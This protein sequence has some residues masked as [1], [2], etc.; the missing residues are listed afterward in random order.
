MQYERFESKVIKVAN[1][2][3]LI[4][5]HMAKIIVA[6][7]VLLLAIA[8]LLFSKGIVLG[9]ES[10]PT[11]ITYGEELG[12]KAKAFLSKVTYEYRNSSGGDWTAE[13]PVSPGD[14][15]V[16]AVAKALFGYRYGDGEDFTI[17]KKEVTVTVSDKAMIYGDDF[18]VTADM[19]YNDKVVCDAFEYNKDKTKVT[20]N[21]NSIHAYDED[22]ND[23]S[24]RY[25]FSTTEKSIVYN[26]RKI[27]IKT[28][29]ATKTY[30]GTPLKS[31]AYEI[32]SGTLAYD[33]KITLT[34][35]ENPT[36]AGTAK[37][38]FTYKIKNKDGVDVT[39]FYSVTSLPG[40]LTIN[41]RDITIST[42]SNTQQ[43]NGTSHTVKKYEIVGDGA[44]LSSHKL[45]CED[46][47]VAIDAGETKNTFTPKIVDGG[48]NSVTD[49]YNVIFNAGII[50]ITPKP[51]TITTSSENR[52]YSGEYWSNTS[53]TTSGLVSGDE[54][55]V[56]SGTE[57]K[58]VGS[59]ENLVSFTVHNA[60][61]KRDVTA[62]YTPTFVKGTLSVD[63]RPITIVSESA[64]WIYNGEELSAPYAYASDSKGMGIVDNHYI[65]VTS[66][67]KVKNVTSGVKN[68]IVAEIHENGEDVSENF[69]ISYSYGTLKVSKRDLYVT[70][71]TAEQYF[72]KE[73]LCSTEAELFN[74]VEGDTI[75]VT[76]ST[77]I[78]YPSTVYNEFIEYDIIDKNNQSVK[79]NYNVIFTKGTLT[80]HKRPVTVITAS[81]TKVYDGTPLRA[82]GWVVAEDSIC[83]LLPG[84]KIVGTTTG[85]QTDAGE[86]PNY[87]SGSVLV[88]SSKNE[89]LTPYYDITPICGTLTVT[90]RRIVV[91]TQDGEAMYDDKNHS[92][93][94]AKLILLGESYDL[95]SGHKIKT[96]SYTVFRDAVIEADNILE[97]GVYRNNTPVTHNYEIEYVYGKVTITPRPITVKTGSI[98]VMYDDKE[99]YN[100]SVSVVS[101]TYGLVSGH[102]ITNVT[103]TMY[104]DSV[105][106]GDNVVFFSI[107]RSSG[108]D[109]TANYDISYKY[110]RVNITPRPITIELYGYS[111]IYDGLPHGERFTVK[112]TQYGLCNG[113][114]VDID[115]NTLA[116]DVMKNADNPAMALVISGDRDVTANY[117]ITYV[118]GKITIDPRT[119]YI[120]TESMSWPYDAKPHKHEEYRV[121]GSS[122]VS[123]HTVMVS[124]ATT[125]TNVGIKDNV[126]G[127]TVFD[128][129]NRDV[130]SNYDIVTRKY[131]ILEITGS[132]Y[133][134]DNPD[135]DHSGGGGG[136]QLSDKGTIGISGGQLSTDGTIGA[137]ELD[138]DDGESAVLYYVTST[139]GGTVYFKLKSFGAYK[140]QSWAEA[141]EYAQH[142]D[143]LGAYYLSTKSLAGSGVSESFMSITS[144]YNQYILPY[145]SDGGDTPQVSDVY[146]R[147]DASKQYSVNFYNSS[148]KNGMTVPAE[149]REFESNYNE[150][151]RQYLAIDSE[152]LAFMNELIAENGFDAK[153]P[154]VLN[155]VA[156]YVQNAASYSLLYNRDL[157]KSPNIAVAFLRD[158]KEGICQHY[159]TSATMLFRAL[160]IPARYTVGFVADIKAGEICEIRAQ[161]AHA[162]VEVYISGFGWVN[163]EVTGG[164]AGGIGGGIG[165]GTGDGD[166]QEP[167]KEPEKIYITPISQYKE[168]DGL[169]LY[170][171]N[172]I[173][174]LD[175]VLSRL[176]AAGYTY[177]VTVGG[178]LY[179]RGVTN[180][181]VESFRLYDPQ[182]NEVTEEYNI[183]Y[184]EGI[185]EISSGIIKIYLYEKRF[186]YSGTKHYYGAQEYAVVSMPSGIKFVLNSVNISMTNVGT[187]TS[188]EINQ[189]ITDYL[190]FS[191]YKNG[192]TTDISEN[193]TVMV[194]NWGDQG[195]Y[196]PFEI[197]KRTITITTA[198]QTKKYD[199]SPLTNN[200]FYVSYGE[201][202]DGHKIN[203]DVIGT[204][205][206]VGISHNT[207]NKESLIIF[208]SNGIDL[209]ANYEVVIIPGKLEVI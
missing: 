93:T 185:L 196:I 66:S 127:L 9:S 92:F 77:S 119:V 132:D 181:Y 36:N 157:D 176:L 183:I 29:D 103:P 89:N 154:D 72:N 2:L 174:E 161:Q 104:V 106:D 34:F 145:Y 170:A 59:T 61:R 116:K 86:S 74:Q 137:P 54:I 22:G 172:E 131:G 64:S 20:V 126:L 110:G 205:T 28:S 147:G 8:A 7:S 80:V 190:N 30:D 48:N 184:N 191:V 118:R 202:A 193:Y 152:T 21:V 63:P 98:S 25:V 81:A 35:T 164:G 171:K 33:D 160:G 1:F 186:E 24:D 71:A 42:A 50:K 146:V 128:E 120:E 115:E 26:K 167:P 43:Y 177:E 209:T 141:K 175:P 123:F 52:F 10:Y 67:T 12:Y 100:S 156:S 31:E 149:L 17:A 70:T 102:K 150:F 13:V 3:K 143:G 139:S 140:G 203:L 133:N 78:T 94:T 32:V 166:S 189:S 40:N 113:H 142:F 129:Y 136:G 206:A 44:L 198:S 207:V 195:E 76:K 91:Q 90:P 57:I 27:T 163:V 82:E 79:N 182:G 23:V 124:N 37:N 130:T 75:V 55:L 109:V 83:D 134:P 45:L 169:P 162:W 19:A 60:S 179:G 95:V 47:V 122:F 85:S 165:D 49:N 158:Y 51:L 187:L 84:D 135:N 46:W 99:H 199:G 96:V 58:Y 159:A 18:L 151:V 178:V 108:E 153:D 53:V 88:Y 125:I 144:L 173:S 208:D 180:C 16:R 111:G 14:Y 148:Y 107:V 68:I 4:S 105:I 11:L 65:V 41:K 197:I 101:G 6:G 5:K 200:S 114:Y 192:S 194:V 155:K 15:Q 168:Y 38:S 188:N 73:P 87:Y 69:A 56:S 138:A 62:N 112:K 121:V 201:L 39:E 204:I 97:V 117:N